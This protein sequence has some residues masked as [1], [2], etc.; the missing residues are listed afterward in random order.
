MSSL[1]NS[2]VKPFN[3]KAYHAKDQ[4]G[5][6]ID[7]TEESLNGD[8]SVFVF[9][10]ADFTFVCPTELSDLADHYEELK[11]LN[12][13]I[14]AIST[15]THFSHKAWHDSSES[16]K[17]IKF[18]MLADPTGALARN[19]DV[20]IE[21]EGLALRGTFIINSEGKIK[22]IEVNDLGI[23]RS[24]GDL[25]RKVQ[26][27]QHIEANP[28]EVCPASWKPGAETLKPSLDL[29]GKI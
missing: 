1:I 17:K 19:F 3:N 24:A 13:E 23:G 15:D 21:E 20:M 6:F 4:Y 2:S 7:I 11:K 14:Y 5:E 22:T 10:P 9:Y 8:W 27:A 18:P 26:A 28:D 25:V 12:V 16:I 29:V